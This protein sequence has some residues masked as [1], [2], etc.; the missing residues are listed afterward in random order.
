MYGARRFAHAPIDEVIVIARL[1]AQG[2]PTTREDLL[3]DNVSFSKGGVLTAN[4]AK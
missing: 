1:E 4:K 3:W 2:I